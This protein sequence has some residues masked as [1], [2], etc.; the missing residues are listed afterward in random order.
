MT[1]YFFQNVSLVLPISSTF[2]YVMVIFGAPPIKT[3][4]FR[5]AIFCKGFLSKKP[6]YGKTVLSVHCSCYDLWTYNTVFPNFVFSLDPPSFVM[7][8]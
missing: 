2:F 5:C 8:N 1:V 6:K 7:G 4:N 3:A